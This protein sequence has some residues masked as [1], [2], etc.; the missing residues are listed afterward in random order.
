MFL[1]SDL[2]CFLYKQGEAIVECG[3]GLSYGFFSF[4]TLD[5]IY[6]SILVLEK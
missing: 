1:V 2:N 5:I 6:V 3:R 4:V